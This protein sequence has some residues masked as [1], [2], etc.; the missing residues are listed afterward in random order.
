MCVVAQDE[1]DSGH[2][3]PCIKVYGCVQAESPLRCK[4]RVSITYYGAYYY[5][6]ALGLFVSTVCPPWSFHFLANSGHRESGRSGC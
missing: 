3:K 2:L 1:L 6:A 5:I 4:A